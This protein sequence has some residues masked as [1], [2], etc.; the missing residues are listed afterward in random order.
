MRWWLTEHGGR[1]PYPLSCLA[2]IAATVLCAL[3][4]LDLCVTLSLTA[5][6]ES[7]VIERHKSGPDPGGGGSNHIRPVIRTDRSSDRVRKPGR[8]INKRGDWYPP[9]Q[10]WEEPDWNE[11]EGQMPSPR[12]QVPSN[13]QRASISSLAKSA[14]KS[15][16]AAAGSHLSTKTTKEQDSSLHTSYC[17]RTEERTLSRCTPCSDT[18]PCPA[19]S[20]PRKAG[21]C[22]L[23]GEHPFMLEDGCL[24]QCEMQVTVPECCNGYWGAQC[25]GKVKSRTRI[26]ESR[27]TLIQD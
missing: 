7:L 2:A 21:P 16:P 24:Y 5:Q 10:G 6:I 23:R 26:P 27:L 22:V 14:S 19:D 25:I 4:I 18:R 8:T 1:Q 13:R 12:K 9:G 3:S 20:V 17:N 15:R 11:H